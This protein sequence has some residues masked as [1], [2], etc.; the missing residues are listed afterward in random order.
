MI[1]TAIGLASLFLLLALG[2][3]LGYAM[4]LV[5][6]AGFAL[7]IGPDAAVYSAGQVIFDNVMSFDL[8]I[9]PLFILMGS[10][11]ARS[12]LAEDLF[13]VA[14][15]FL[16]HRRGGLA[17]FTVAACGGFSCVCG[18]SMATVATM[19]KVA[20]P[21]MR[22]RGY[23][24][25]LASASIVSGGTLGILI[26]PSTTLVI[27]GI[28][29]ETNIGKLFMAAVLPGLIAVS[30]LMLAV[31]TTVLL[32]PESG[33][34]SERQGWRKRLFYLRRTGGVIVLFVGMM[35]GIYL[36][37]FTVSEAAG[38]GAAGSLLFVLWRRA[39]TW[40]VLKDAL[41]DAALTT[42][43]IFVIL[44][45]AL[46]FANFI[47]VTGLPGELKAWVASSH[48]TPIALILMITA[49]YF[50]MGM[51]LEI[52]SMM[53]LTVPLFLPMV[54]AIG[55]DPVWFGIFVILVC[56]LGLITPPVGL[57][58]FVFRA[59]ARDISVAAISRG[60]IPFI[61]ALLAVVGI[62]VSMPEV[63]SFLPGMMG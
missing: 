23:A 26:P 50:V 56:E 48:L 53:L 24:S 51:V 6:F 33:P 54:T 12:G 43:T 38:I 28:I 34:R 63:V 21:S 61:I 30:L 27:Y 13:G 37:V 32:H 58:L 2:V 59:T 41:T 36:G 16:G 57:N 9:L 4:A 40:R 46:I 44:F 5:G 39:L 18:S 17:M 7:L 22:Q 35:G 47:E 49:V 15:A 52:L 20:L 8:S 60:L 3:P 10:F 45:G 19:A 25:S 55:Y 11:I 31:L 29:T 14:E 62:I 1:L 42:A